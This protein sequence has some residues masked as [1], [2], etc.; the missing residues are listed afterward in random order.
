[1]PY[2]LIEPVWTGNID[3]EEIR[4]EDEDEQM[5]QISINCG[6]Y[7]EVAGGIN[8]EFYE[9]KL[10]EA[11]ECLNLSDDY[12]KPGCEWHIRKYDP[13]GNDIWEE[14]IYDWFRGDEI[15]FKLDD[16][17]DEDE[18][19]PTEYPYKYGYKFM[20]NPD[21]DGERPYIHIS[22]GCNRPVQECVLG[23]QLEAQ[24]TIIHGELMQTAEIRAQADQLLSIEITPEL[25][26][27]LREKRV[28]M[29]QNLC[30]RYS[31]IGV[32]FA[33]NDDGTSNVENCCSFEKIDSCYCGFDK[34]KYCCILTPC[35]DHKMHL[36]CLY[37]MEGWFR[38]LGLYL[39]PLI[40]IP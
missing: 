6:R 19:H 20:S 16:C 34:N 15:A 11:K 31:G 17:D 9:K 21:P 12:D 3:P 25:R 10:E 1:M 33:P 38:S 37:L 40:P 27:E 23:E 28:E 26:K 22:K 13:N 24:C 14:Y 36:R 5:T 8:P 7:Y 30:N 39:I 4:D 2:S 18:N 29:Y 35:C 32:C